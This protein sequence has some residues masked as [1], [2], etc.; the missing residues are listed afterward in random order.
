MYWWLW[1]PPV[2][3]NDPLVW[4]WDGRLAVPKVLVASPPVYPGWYEP[5][6]AAP[7]TNLATKLGVPLFPS[8]NAQPVGI[9]FAA[10]F[11]ITIMPATKV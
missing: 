3:D 11:H 7:I 10:P 1:L 6:P 8:H 5:L 9:A 2:A 4:V